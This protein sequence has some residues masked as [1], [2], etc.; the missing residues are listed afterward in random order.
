[1]VSYQV[2]EAGGI[3]DA[4]ETG[5]RLRDR[6]VVDPLLRPCGQWAE[7]T[8]EQTLKTVGLALEST[9]GPD[10]ER[11]GYTAVDTMNRTHGG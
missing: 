11:R 1:M 6:R 3:E 5:V 10:A 2:L 4:V 7:A 8:R 9:S